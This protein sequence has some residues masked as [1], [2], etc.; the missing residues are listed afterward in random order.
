MLIF[1]HYTCFEGSYLDKM[2]SGHSLIHERYAMLERKVP[3]LVDMCIQ[4]AIDNIRYLGDVGQTDLHLLERI[5]PHCKVDQLKH[6]EDSTEV[7]VPIFYIRM[8]NGISSWKLTNG[9]LIYL[10]VGSCRGI[11]A[12][13]LINYGR[14]FMR[15][16]LV[17]IALILSVKG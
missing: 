2:S 5:L 10:L 12:Q 3:S 14:S 13:L 9:R 7:R 4:L 6:I 8:L 17:L 15:K 16:N 1:V 11:L